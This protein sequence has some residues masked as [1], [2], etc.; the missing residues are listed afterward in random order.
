ML[1]EILEKLLKLL[2]NKI[3]KVVFSFSFI[4]YLLADLN[5]VWI[6]L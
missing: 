5:G 4:I 3:L 2:P 1:I 6:S